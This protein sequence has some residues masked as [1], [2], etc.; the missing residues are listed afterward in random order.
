MGP[1]NRGGGVAEDQ[2]V[3]LWIL[4]RPGA[5]GDPDGF[6]PRTDLAGGDRITRLQLRSPKDL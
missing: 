3:A 4:M 1:H 5:V 2:L 6:Q